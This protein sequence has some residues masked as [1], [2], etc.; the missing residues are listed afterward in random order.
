MSKSIKSVAIGL[1]T[2]LVAPVASFASNITPSN[3]GIASESSKLSRAVS[4]MDKVG[5]V[6]GVASND[7]LNVRSSANTNSSSIG[8]MS[9]GETL[10][11]TGKDGEWYQIN[12]YGKVG[13]VYE[14]YAK[15]TGDISFK[16]T[17]D[18][19]NMRT[20]ASTS[21]EIVTTIPKNTTVRVLSTSNGWSRIYYNG[22]F[23]YC[24][25]TYLESNTS[26]TSNS[27][28]NSSSSSTLT[29]MNKEG[30]VT[31]VASNDTLNVRSTTNTSGSIVT[32]I[33]N[34]T[35][36]QVVG[37]DKAT[38]WYKIV[39]NGYT[40]Y[41]SNKYIT[42]VGDWN[43]SST[44]ITTM[45]KE[46]K[47]TGVA[48]NDTLNVRST[49][50]TSG[51]IVTKITNGTKVQVVGQDKA[52]GWYKIV[53][54]GYTGY[55][56]N[57]YITIVGDWNGSSTST[58]VKK[59]TTANL[60]L[61]TGAGT[62][63]PIIKT[64]ASNT[65]VEVLETSGGW[66]KIKVGSDIGYVSNN[67]L[68]DSN[69]SSSNS[70]LVS[71]KPLYSKVKVVVDAGH[72]GTDPGAIGNGLKEKD[73]VLSI[74]KKVNSKLQSLGFKTV[75]TRSNDTYISL[76]QRY[77]IANNNNADLFVSIHA[78]SASATNANGIET[79]YKGSK[80]LAQSIQTQLINQ[81]GANNRGLK[82]RTDLAVLNGTKMPSALVEVGF[83]S[84]ASEASKIGNNSYQEKL[85]TAIV[86]GLA[87]YTDGNINK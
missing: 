54:N 70:G 26:S 43:S 14:K 21:H 50:N 23:G 16:R 68:A 38:G 65:V 51:S 31:G 35:K 56:S 53:V 33:T 10:V 41:V 79:L 62:N 87:K 30:K 37:Q 11:I 4:S 5:T 9:N 20:G 44:S 77:S 13:Y 46:G 52:T 81:T 71:S 17:T 82:Y 75:M 29:T 19:L 39:V 40:G 60:N 7:Y 76:S 48:S 80:A 32:K 24:S 49:T 64:I 57:K 28:S 55:V 84:N 85:A 63:Y 45:N 22:K 8:K 78:N 83:I 59:V 73:I 74:S 47:V 36:V 15:I 66:S 61:R 67:Y 6:I 2:T 12:Y 86:N 42:I 27:S 18:N 69:S 25:N 72:G 34:G 3:E 58:T 1:A